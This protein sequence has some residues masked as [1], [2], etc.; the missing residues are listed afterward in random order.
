MGQQYTRF[1]MVDEN[2]V[3]D[4]DQEGNVLL[5]MVM[6]AVVPDPVAEC[7]DP[8]HDPD[9]PCH[10]YLA[11]IGDRTAKFATP[12]PLPDVG[13]AGAYRKVCVVALPRE[14]GSATNMR[15]LRVLCVVPVPDIPWV[16]ECLG[17]P[18][19]Y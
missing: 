16:V 15:R 19:I 10:H 6:A 8:T 5:G 9:E 14:F 11:H 13:E 2:Q 3:Q 12:Q 1:A 7:Q 18:A 4:L 17:A